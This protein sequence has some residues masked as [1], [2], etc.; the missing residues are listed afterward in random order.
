MKSSLLVFILVI[1][2]FI[3]SY[4]TEVSD[5]T[6]NQPHHH[7]SHDHHSAEHKDSHE[8]KTQQVS[9]SEVL[10][11]V[12]GMVCSFCAQGIEKNFKAKKEVKETKVDLD[13]MEVRVIFY[14]NQSLSSEQI[15]EVITG[16][17]FK[18]LGV[19]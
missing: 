16:A 14:P 12:S 15:K 1:Y 9:K 7:K 18:F 6:P 5:K 8:V 4:A 11:K 10:V 2:S 13:K 17:G 3:N 19:E